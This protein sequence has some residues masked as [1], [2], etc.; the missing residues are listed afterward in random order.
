MILISNLKKNFNGNEL[1]SIK[2]LSLKN[3]GFY[4]IHGRSG[5]G[6]TTLLNILAL[7]D[8]NYTGNIRINGKVISKLNDDELSSIRHKK[9]SYIHQKPVLFEDMTVVDN[10]K[11]F[12]NLT[13]DAIKK[14]LINVKLFGKCKIKAK[15]LSGGEKQKICILRALLQNKD[16]VICDEPTGNINASAAIEIINYLK[17]LS[18]SKLVIVV[19]HQLSLY[20]DKADYIY[21][22][23]DKNIYLK[24]ESKEINKVLN[25]LLLSFEKNNLKFSFNRKYIKLILSKNKFRNFLISFVMTLSFISL[26]IIFLLR[27]NIINT[28]NNSLSMFYEPNEVLINGKNNKV[29]HQKRNSLEIHEIEELKTYL[30]LETDIQYIYENN[31]ETFFPD[32][33][34]LFLINGYRSSLLDGYNA[35]NFNEFLMIDEAADNKYIKYNYIKDDEVIISIDNSL[36]L[37]IC[38]NLRIEKSF[39]SLYKKINTDDV[40]VS[41]FL[42]NFSWEYEDEQILRISGFV[43]DTKKVIYHSNPI[44]NTVLFEKQ[45]KLPFTVYDEIQEKPWTLKKTTVI[46]LD[47]Q[48]ANMFIYDKRLNDYY[49]NKLNWNYTPLL[50]KRDFPINNGKYVIYK[51]DKLDNINLDKLNDISGEDKFILNN[52]M[53]INMSNGFANG[54]LNNLFFST[55]LEDMNYIIDNYYSS[56]ERRKMSFSTDRTISCGVLSNKSEN[57]KF[58]ISDVKCKSYNSI[59]IS[60]KLSKR[61]LLD[62]SKEVYVLSDDLSS[63][64][65]NYCLSK[66]IID[67]VLGNEYENIIYGNNYA[68]IEFFRDVLYFD[69]NLY[70]PTQLKI[71]MKNDNTQYYKALFN[72]EHVSKPFEEISTQ[73]EDILFYFTFA[74]E[75]FCICCILIAIFLFVIISLSI[76]VDSNRNIAVLYSLGFS[77]RKIIRIYS[78]YIAKNVGKSLIFSLIFIFCMSFSINQIINSLLRTSSTFTLYFEPF[79]SSFLLSIMLYLI[80]YIFQKRYIKK[81]NVLLAIR[82]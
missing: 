28:L 1:F 57:I 63:S 55:S 46:E 27:I 54:F 2:T 71:M 3:N 50:I 58:D 32:G 61:L 25:P 9:I 17:N 47:S 36:M 56:N 53:Y 30:K 51:K 23:L 59:K 5:C 31:F 11:Y 77:K 39:D 43:V 6:K 12:T 21:E 49:L 62:D 29:L 52:N 42:K 41:L 15:N 80:T 81:M 14:A 19:S 67:E 16:I 74:I 44:F 66:I 7:M 48:Q 13:D 73:I 37:E 10:L 45:M 26:S 18:K 60:S 75:I 40:Y 34:S 38:T 79:V 68:I 4:L 8:K 35:R 33:N 78:L 76:T 72:K 24:K 82:N 65:N 20:Q 69:Y 22:M 70:Q 64:K